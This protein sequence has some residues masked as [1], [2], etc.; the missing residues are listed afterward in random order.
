VDVGSP[1]PADAQPAMLVQPAERALHDPALPPE[2]G[3]VRGLLAGDQRPDAPLAHGPAV[4]VVVVAAVA[5]DR[6]GPTTRS[7]H[8]PPQARHGVDQRYE[9]G[10]V[11]AVAACEADGERDAAGIGQEVVL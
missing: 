11:V 5:H 1:L 3:A 2:P 6:V 10:D 7:A 8:P 4:V 9:L